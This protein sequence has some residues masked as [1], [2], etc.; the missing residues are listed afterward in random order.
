MGMIADLELAVH[1]VG[2]HVEQ[3][4]SDVGVTH[5]EAHVLA[6]LNRT[7]ELTIGELQHAS[8]LKRSTLTN[9]LD[10][11]EERGFVERRPNA[12]D[13]RSTVVSLSR[14]GASAAG[15]VSETL[16]QLERALRRRVSA[17]DLAGVRAVAAA[18]AEM[19]ADRR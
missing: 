15:H 17:R 12:D 16:E 2:H 14:A 8:G 7:A 19:T 5:A 1:L 3:A 10:R 9:V 18:L 4:A 11:L 13:R 6:H